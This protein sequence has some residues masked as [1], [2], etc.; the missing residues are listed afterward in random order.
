MW[1]TELR[2][3]KGATCPNRLTEYIKDLIMAYDT[4]FLSAQLDVQTS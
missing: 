2:R 4:N 1:C 3:Y